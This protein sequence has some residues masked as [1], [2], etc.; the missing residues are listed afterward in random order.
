[1]TPPRA[2]SLCKPERD[3]LRERPVEAAL[4]SPVWADEMRVF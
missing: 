2:I 1:M 3:A 4:R